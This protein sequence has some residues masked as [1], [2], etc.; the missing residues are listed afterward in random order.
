MNMLKCIIVDDEQFSVDAIM[1]YINL[2]PNL[3]VIGVYTDPVNALQTISAEDDV[4]LLF[5]DIDMPWLSGLELAKALRS[6]TQKLVFTTA[7]SKYAFDAFEVEG[8]AF[9]LKPF[10]FGKFSTTINRLFPEKNSGGMATAQA[11]ND[12]FLIKSK[13]DDLAIVKI[14]YNDVIA[15]ESLQN[16]VKIYLA[17]GKTLIAYLTLKDVLQ[18][19][20]PKIEFK[21]FHRAFII[22]TD[23]ISQIKGNT[24]QMSNGLSFPVGDVYKEQFCNYLEDKLLLTSRKR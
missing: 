24:I 5:M 9:L 14:K 2:T 12:Y 6:K 3:D 10:T 18:L 23:C 7:H 4:D 17:S 19:L 1:K 15:F 21:Q 11:E 8:D 16:Y 22:S 13:E 20:K